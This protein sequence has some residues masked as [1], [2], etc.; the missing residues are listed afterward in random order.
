MRFASHPDFR[1]EGSDLH[2]ELAVAPWEAVL[3]AQVQIPALEGAVSMR[4]PAGSQAGQ[5]LRLRG[6]GLPAEDGKRGDLY[7][8][9][10]IVA[11]ETVSAAERKLWEEL[12]R[13]SSFRPRS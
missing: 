3:G 10:Q 4:V 12:A 11:P 2:Y 9:L 6:L 8:T 13:T 1:V 7:A 5:Q